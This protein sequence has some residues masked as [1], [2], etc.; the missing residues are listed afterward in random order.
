MFVCFTLSP[1]GHGPP[2]GRAPGPPAGG[3]G[4]P[5]NAFG[6]LLTVV[7]LGIVVSEK[8]S[9][10]AF[11]V[12]ILIPLLV[13]MMLFI[14]RQYARI[15][16][17]SSR[18][19]PTYVVEPPNREERAIVPVPEL[20]RAAVQAVNVAR[21]I[22]DAGRRPSTSAT[23]RRRSAALRE[24]WER[25][26]P[27]VP[28][29]IVESPYRALVGPLVAYLDV[30]DRA[31]PPDKPA[32]ITFVVLPEYVARSWWERILYN[33]SARRLR[34]RPARADRTRSSSTCRTG[35]T[36]PTGSS[37][38]GRRARASTAAV[39]RRRGSA[40][41]RG[42]TP[43]ARRPAT[44]AEP[45]AVYRDAARRPVEARPEVS[46]PRSSQ[47]RRL[48]VRGRF[49]GT[50][51]PARRRGAVRWPNRPA[52][53]R[54]RRRAGARPARPSSSA[55]TSSRSTG[56]CPLDA[57]VAGRSE[58]AQRVLDI[59]EAT[60][61]AGHYQLET[62]LLQARDVG[63]AIVDEATERG[64]DLVIAGLPFRRRFGGDFA[65]GRTIP[66]IL[67]NAPCAVWVIREAMP[68]EQ[69]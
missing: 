27:G 51:V 42:P 66:Y 65:I 62:V 55:S 21:S 53:R 46:R 10:G 19:R 56:R 8:F 57:D 1:G 14:H 30:L 36:T 22:S 38:R 3:G 24:R 61:E 9:G 26:V 2:L 59:A 48:L 33:Q 44:A 54:P 25:Q 47:A 28:L 17:R 34:S 6:A 60:A 39:G 37:D 29:V 67:K 20:N 49:G 13:G 64:A 5:I 18:S 32:P 15:G 52:D 31:W 23:T 43:A 68:E 50:A 7:V 12:V 40:D 58:D 69:A 11:V 45:R 63:A 35:A 16:A 41:R 4:W